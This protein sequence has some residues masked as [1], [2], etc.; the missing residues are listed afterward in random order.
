MGRQL[1]LYSTS[2][3]SKELFQPSHDQVEIYCCG[4]T[5]YN[6]AHIGNL[7]TYIFEDVLVKTLRALNYKV[8]HVMNITD[9]GHLTSDGDTGDDKMEKGAVR[10]GKTVWDIAACYTDA[11]KRDLIDLNIASPDEWPKATDHIA[12]MISMIQE[13]ER[14]G[15]TYTIR[16]GVYFNTA[17]FPAYSNFAHINVASL[18]AG[19]RVEMGEKRNVTDFALWKFSPTDKTRQMEWDSPWGKGFPGWHIECSAMALAYLPQPIDIHC[20]GSDHVRVHHTNEIAQAEA[21]TG[22]PYVRYWLHGEFLTI[23]KGKMA[24]SGEN[25]MTLDSVKTKGIPPLAYR[26]FCYSA[27]YRSP[28]MFSWESLKAALQGLEHLKKLIQVETR[29]PSADIAE[30]SPEVLERLLAPFWDALCDDLNMPVA[31]AEIWN[32]LHD[33]HIAGELK[34]KAIEQ[35]ERITALDLLKW[36]PVRSVIEGIDEGDFKVTFIA[37]RDPGPDTLQ[38]IMANLRERKQAKQE[39]NF[40]KADALRAELIEMGAHVRDLPGGTVECTLS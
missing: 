40:F 28:L 11:F 34:F 17:K 33:R 20:G 10:E 13:L 21:A 23:D 24:K 1:F 26:M 35:I 32:L 6:Y 19:A 39:R 38:R 4:P 37:A 16:D 36:E 3:L 27:H 9:V 15:F 2:S 8:K 7:R 22:K 5:V 30:V 25:F 14:R 18:Q 12:P 31:M 29:R